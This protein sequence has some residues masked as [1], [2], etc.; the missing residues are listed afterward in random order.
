ML[1]MG[2]VVTFIVA[3]AGI[4]IL[5]VLQRNGPNLF[6]ELI[7]LVL[8]FLF[9]V[10]LIYSLYNAIT[11]KTNGSKLQKFKTVLLG[12]FVIPFFLLIIYLDDTDG[13]KGKLI[14][15]GVNNDLSLIHFDLYND[16][17][18]KLLNSGPFGGQYYRG[19]YTLKKD[20]LKLD[21]DSLMY[22]FPTLTFTLKERKDKRIF[23][24]PTDTGKYKMILYIQNDYR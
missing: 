6:Y 1:K 15:G 8:Y 10:S 11:D 2:R 7:Q 18:F 20:T 4:L 5:T 9:I 17:T 12:L 16:N 19:K 24:E 22:L 13:G 23:L 14:S 3:F 21:N